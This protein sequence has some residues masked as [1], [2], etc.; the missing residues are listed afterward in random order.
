M[1]DQETGAL[2]RLTS[3]EKKVN[4]KAVLTEATEVA[5]VMLS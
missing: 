1:A 5:V 3:G 4:P 2:V